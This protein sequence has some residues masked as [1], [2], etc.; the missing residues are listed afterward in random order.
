MGA[1]GPGPFD[2]DDAMD[3]LLDYEG[4][5]VGVLLDVLQ[6]PNDAEGDGFID[7]PLGGQLIALGEI[8]AACHGRPFTAGPSDY[9][10]GGDPARLQAQMKA[11]AE[12]VKAEPRLLEG[13]RA[14]VNGLLANPKVSEL[15]ALWQEGEQLEGFARTIS[16]LETRLRKVAT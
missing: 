6:E 3:L 10:M 13:A 4:Q 7:A 8:V 15:A 12:A 2:N 16:D 5:G 14:A 11:H 1:W 9:A